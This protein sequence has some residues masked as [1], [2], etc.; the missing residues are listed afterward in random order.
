[1]KCKRVFKGVPMIL[2]E[3]RKDLGF[4]FTIIFEDKTSERF[5]VTI[6]TEE[7]QKNMVRE[8]MH[9]TALLKDNFKELA[10][11]SKKFVDYD[12]TYI[13]ASK[14]Y[15]DSIDVKEEDYEYPVS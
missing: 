14:S 3:E 10:A 1:M 15:Y 7:F 2:D 11:K 13:S 6:P 12:L 4:E 5:T 8:L 9:I